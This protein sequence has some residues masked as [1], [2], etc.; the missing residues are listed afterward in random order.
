[1]TETERC[2]QKLNWI[3]DKR[4]H[5]TQV[6]GIYQYGDE[7]IVKLTAPAKSITI[8]RFSGVED[9]LEKICQGVENYINHE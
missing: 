7:V 3:F 5:A 1:M 6:E 2:I 9:L 8:T 4:K